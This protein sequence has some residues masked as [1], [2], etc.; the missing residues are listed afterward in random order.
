MYTNSF[1][2]SLFSH[3]KGICNGLGFSNDRFAALRAP[4]WLNTLKSKLK[5]SFNK[6][7]WDFSGTSNKPDS[8]ALNSGQCAPALTADSIVWSGETCKHSTT[9]KHVSIIYRSRVNSSRRRVDFFFFPCIPRLFFFF[10]LLWVNSSL[11]SLPGVRS[12]A[13]IRCSANLGH[14]SPGRP[15]FNIQVSEPQDTGIS[16]ETWRFVPSW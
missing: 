8:A 7:P 4:Q 12:A 1:I 15:G 9:S 13:T 6:Q 5:I 11:F 3:S 16:L 10:F 14:F 2:G